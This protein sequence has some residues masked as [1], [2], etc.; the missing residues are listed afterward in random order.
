[1]Q[2]EESLLEELYT[3]GGGFDILT[4]VEALKPILSIKRGGEAIYF[5]SQGN[6]LKNENKILSVCLVQKLLNQEGVIEDGGISGKRILELTDLPKGT[7]DN[8]IHTLKKK[9]LIVGSGKSYEI[10]VR[11]LEAVISLINNQG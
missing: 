8:C 2:K 3:D 4:V 9:G 5:T 10:P 7:I 11:N 1:M 6:S